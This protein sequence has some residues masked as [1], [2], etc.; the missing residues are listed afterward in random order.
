MHNL[1]RFISVMKLRPW[2][3]AIYLNYLSR[4]I[5][6]GA[7]PG[8]VHQRDEVPA[9][10]LADHPPLHTRRQGRGHNRPRGDWVVI[11]LSIY[12]ISIYLYIYLYSI[13]LRLSIRLQS[14]YS[15]TGWGHNRPRGDR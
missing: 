9:P 14:T 13:N 2:G 10:G 8:S 1:G 4:S 5:Y 12:Y 3:L 7:Q 11:Y 15:P 6:L